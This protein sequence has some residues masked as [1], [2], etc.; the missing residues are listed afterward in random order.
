MILN[1]QKDLHRSRAG[2]TIN[3][4]KSGAFAAMVKIALYAPKAQRLQAFATL[5][6]M[7]EEN[8]LALMFIGIPA[9]RTGKGLQ[10]DPVTEI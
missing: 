4:R 1:C 2:A 5:A 7:V 8:L 3:G 9:V 10:F 6:N